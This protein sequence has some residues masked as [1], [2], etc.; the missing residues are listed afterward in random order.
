MPSL[1]C[2]K[3]SRFIG[4]PRST[5]APV[6]MRRVCTL[7]PT[8]P[9]NELSGSFLGFVASSEFLCSLSC[10]DPFGPKLAARVSSLSRHHGARPLSR[11]FSHELPGIPTPS[12]VPSTGA[13]NLSTVFSA[14]P[15]CG[16][17]SSRSRRPG[18]FQLVQGFVVSAQPRFLIGSSFPLAVGASAAR[19]TRSGR[20]RLEH[21]DFEALLRGGARL[22]QAR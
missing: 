4:S 18:T 6:S 22:P 17:V 9:L 20:P 7:N 8:V 11:D 13:L 21:L 10:S 15:L 16:L 12:F 1:V 2:W 19:Q 14:L 5:A 3:S